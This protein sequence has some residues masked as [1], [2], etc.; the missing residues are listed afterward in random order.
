MDVFQ[1]L[2]EFMESV[3]LTV[4]EYVLMAQQPQLANMKESCPEYQKLLSVPFQITVFRTEKC[5]LQK[6]WSLQLQPF[7]NTDVEIVNFVK[8]RATNFRLFTEL[9]RN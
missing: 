5:S 1:T 3:G 2:D 8:A 9:C 4:L 6:T 7:M